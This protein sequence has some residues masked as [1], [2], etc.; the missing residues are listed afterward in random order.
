[1][2]EQDAKT[3]EELAGAVRASGALGRSQGLERLFDYL[4]KASIE[5]RAPREIEIA[6]DVFGRLADGSGDASVRV[7]VHRLRRKLEAFAASRPADHRRL[8]IPLGEY[9]L[10]V[11]S[12]E[13]PMI[14][15]PGVRRRPTI[16]AVLALLAVVNLAAF[17]LIVRMV[18]AAPGLSR[19]A[20]APIWADIGRQ[21]PILIV[22][23][24]YYIFGDTDHEDAP[25]R[26]IRAFEINSPAD[27]DAWLMDNPEYQGRYIDLDTYY[28]PVGATIALRDV[29]PVVRQIA[30]SDKRVAIVTASQLTPEMMKSVDIVYVGYLSGL[31]LLQTL[32]MDRSRFRIGETFDELVD[33]RTG[34]SFVSG[35]GVASTGRPNRDYGYLAGFRGPAG[36][37]F[38]IIAG[39]RDIGVMQA[40]ETAVDPKLAPRRDASGSFEALYE[41]DGVGR[42]NL[43]ATPVDNAVRR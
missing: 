18:G 28:T 42:T 1:M 31:R 30:R 13:A 11:D 39:A 41:V 12:G 19:T 8:S 43:T 34:Q 36:N 16:L 7:Y 20:A 37:H 14:E 5:G 27:L 15:H 17:G 40:A 6:Q 35:A 21:R 23:G 10:V 32:V 9:R 26:M 22:V 2:L 24:D 4:V 29:A 3:L 25:K 33:R 38:L